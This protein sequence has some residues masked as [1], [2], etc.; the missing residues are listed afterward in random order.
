MELPGQKIENILSLDTG[1]SQ[2][3]VCSLSLLLDW[4]LRKYQQVVWLATNLSIFENHIQIF[5][6]ASPRGAGGL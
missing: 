1:G 3:M 4:C 2:R 6:F 5:R